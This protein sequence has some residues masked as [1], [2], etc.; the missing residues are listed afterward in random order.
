MS[1]QEQ[2]RRHNTTAAELAGRFL[3]HFTPEA[4]GLQ[5]VM[6]EV[7]LDSDHAGLL[8]TF[9]HLRPKSKKG[10]WQG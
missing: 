10:G 3:V 2:Q 1:E 5:S 4:V 7:N 8:V 6:L 9:W